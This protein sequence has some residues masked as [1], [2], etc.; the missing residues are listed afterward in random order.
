MFSNSSNGKKKTLEDF[1]KSMKLFLNESIKFFPVSS[2]TRIRRQYKAL[3]ILRKDGSLKYFINELIP[4]QENIFNKDEK[5]F[6]ES[7]TFMVEDPKM[8]EAWKHLD[9]LTKDIMW[10]HLQVLYCLAYKYL[11]E[12]NLV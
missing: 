11:Q 2:I 6:L 3:N 8:V 12:K 5:T 7:K 1:D 9:N 4:F 10:K